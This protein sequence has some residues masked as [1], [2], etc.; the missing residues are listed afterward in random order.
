MWSCHRVCFAEFGMN[1]I[2]ADKEK[3]SI[4]Q[5]PE[6]ESPIDEPQLSRA[7]PAQPSTRTDS[8]QDRHATCR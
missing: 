7:A 1:V 5:L 6:G 4:A 2:C 3:Q 8:L